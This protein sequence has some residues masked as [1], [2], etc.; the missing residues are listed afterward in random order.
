MGPI[1]AVARLLG[2]VDLQAQLK[3]ILHISSIGQCWWI[4]YG[5]TPLQA[6]VHKNE[7]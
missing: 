6:V 3:Q 5:Y 4:S 2:K 7:L 1:I